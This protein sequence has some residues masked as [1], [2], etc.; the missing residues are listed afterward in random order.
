MR[1]EPAAGQFDADET[2]LEAMQAWN[3]PQEEIDQVRARI[4]E[5]ERAAPSPDECFPVYADNLPTVS[6]FLALRT[7]WVYAGVDGQRT[8]LNYAGVC[9]WIDKHVPSPRRRRPL[10]QGIQ[11]MEHAVLVADYERK[12]QEED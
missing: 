5:R 12:Q 3:A 2:T 9:A 6:A 7:Q 4:A 8:G 1:D 10:M 11:T